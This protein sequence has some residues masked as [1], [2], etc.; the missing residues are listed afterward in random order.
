MKKQHRK[1]S[2]VDLTFFDPVG[3]FP[4][5]G[6]GPNHPHVRIGKSKISMKTSLL[7]QSLPGVHRGGVGEC[8]VEIFRPKSQVFP[9]KCPKN[10][11]KQP[12]LAPFW[13]LFLAPKRRQNRLFWRG[14]LSCWTQKWRNRSKCLNATH[15][16]LL[17]TPHNP[18]NWLTRKIEVC[19]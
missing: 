9:P 6:G 7:D 11:P 5:S 19:G 18:Q 12:I 1:C 2:G 3:A 15:A 17:R 14:F 10:P 4:K 8:C 13:R 16:G